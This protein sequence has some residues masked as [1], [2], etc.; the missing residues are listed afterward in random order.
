[1]RVSDV[2]IVLTVSHSLHNMHRLWTP[3][4][5]KNPLQAL[6]KLKFA[7]GPPYHF[8]CTEKCSNARFKQPESKQL[9]YL[10]HSGR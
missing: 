7:K 8:G 4:H 3:C 9:T 1:M 6:T 5:T 10:V 2:E